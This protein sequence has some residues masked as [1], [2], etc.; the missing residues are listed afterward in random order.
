MLLSIKCLL[1]VFISRVYCAICISNFSSDAF[2]MHTLLYMSWMHFIKT[3]PF[4]FAPLRIYVIFSFPS[5]AVGVRRRAVVW[6]VQGA[7][8]LQQPAVQLLWPARRV[9][10]HQAPARVPAL[11]PAGGP[12]GSAKGKRNSRAHGTG[13]QEVIACLASVTA[14]GLL[15][16]V[17]QRRL[18]K[19]N[20]RHSEQKVNAVKWSN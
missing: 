7:G 3:L 4:Y 11:L 14:R 17:Y 16:S 12:D 1:S 15:L 2:F 18:R 19:C 10:P 5:T 13:K 6:G 9:Q 20:Q 8:L